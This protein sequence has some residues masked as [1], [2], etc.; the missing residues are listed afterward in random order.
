MAPPYLS[1]TSSRG[2]R[3]SAYQRDSMTEAPL[4]YRHEDVG[5]VSKSYAEQVRGIVPGYTGHI[6]GVHD[7][8]EKTYFGP[9]ALIK[10]TLHLSQDRHPDTKQPQIKGTPYR[11]LVNGIIPGY[12]GHIPMASSTY[13]ISARGGIQPFPESPTRQQRNSDDFLKRLV[14]AEKADVRTVKTGEPENPL[15]AE[16]NWWPEMAPSERG[17]RSFRGSVN[18]VL[19][20][21]TGHVP[22]GMYKVGEPK[23]GRIPRGAP[24][25]DPAKLSQRGIPNTKMQATYLGGPACGSERRSHVRS[26]GGP[27]L[28]GYSG[29]VPGGRELVGASFYWTEDG[30]R[31][32][33]TEAGETTEDN[34]RQNARDM[35]I[36]TFGAVGKMVSDDSIA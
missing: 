29:Y 18:G 36:D 10:E 5:S 13:G 28:P 20:G 3:R 16:G 25:T 31:F 23:V 30:R 9:H 32:A 21:Y 35:R 11:A 2:S 4:P 15:F 14:V 7:Q 34:D 27:I 19:P 6:P 17:S 8:V 12:S 33:G 26:D 1:R 22:K 24:N